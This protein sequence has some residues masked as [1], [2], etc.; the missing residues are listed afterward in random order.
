MMSNSPSSSRRSSNSLLRPSQN[1]HD[2]E[3][4]FTRPKP[5]ST[6]VSPRDVA[7]LYVLPPYFSRHAIRHFQLIRKGNALTTILPLRYTY[8]YDYEISCCHYCNRTC[9]RLRC[10]RSITHRERVARCI[11]FTGCESVAFTH[12]VTSG[13][14]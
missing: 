11:S 6:L 4:A 1:R 12:Q 2:G 14:A 3:S 13:F 5:L 8:Y 10:A 7:K 9:H